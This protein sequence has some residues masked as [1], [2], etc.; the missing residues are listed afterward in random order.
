MDGLLLLL[1]R[2]RELSP[3]GQSQG[4]GNGIGT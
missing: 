3:F 4:G 2:L 1:L